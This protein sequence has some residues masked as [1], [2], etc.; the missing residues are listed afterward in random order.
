AGPAHRESRQRHAGDRGRR[1]IDSTRRRVKSVRIMS[2]LKRLRF[3]P[4]AALL[5]VASFYAGTHFITTRPVPPVHPLT[6]RQIAGIATDAGWL[7]RASRER[8][9]APDQALRMIGIHSG[10]VVADVGAGSGYMTTRLAE[11]VGPTG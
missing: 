3:L 11:M 9:E 10:M 7:D 2:A 4:L 1:S 6:G 8:E 5:A